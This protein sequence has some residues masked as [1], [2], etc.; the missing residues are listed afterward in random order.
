[1]KRILILL[2]LIVAGWNDAHA[3][4]PVTNSASTNRILMID[5]SSMPL[6]FGK[7]TL[8]I[9]ILQR[10]NG[11][12]SGNY[13]FKVFPYFLKNEN[14]WM[15][16]VVSDESL[17]EFNRGKVVTIIGTAT[18]NGKGGKIRRV[19]VV[20]T[21]TNI[22]SGKLKIRFMAGDR[23]MLFEPIY[24]FAEKATTVTLAKAAE[25]KP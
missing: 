11:V 10:T 23:E 1:M 14:G 7:A 5:S 19:N 13:K 8:T 18:T 2:A 15:A 16:I 24:H 4:P 12:Y 17:A 22:N 21:P 6:T 3:A 25:I 9:G 20:V